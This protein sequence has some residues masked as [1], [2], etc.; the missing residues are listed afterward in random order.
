MSDNSPNFSI[1][2][3]STDKSIRMSLGKVFN[4][5]RYEVSMYQSLDEFQANVNR[6]AIHCLILSIDIILGYKNFIKNFKKQNSQ[7]S[8]IVVGDRE[9]YGQA[10]TSI[11]AGADDYLFMPVSTLKLRALVNQMVSDKIRNS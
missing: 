6:N 7:S 9:E 1:A 11:Q 2:I 4:S 8:V 3:I 5:K 10:V